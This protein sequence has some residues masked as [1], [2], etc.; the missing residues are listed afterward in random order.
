V[1]QRTNEFGVRLALGATPGVLLRLVLWQAGRVVLIGLA[2]GLAVSFAT[3][4][5]LAN[6]LFG[7]TPHDPLL[8]T[9]VSVLLLCV[10]MLATL[11]PA[12]RAARTDPMEALRYE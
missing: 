11:L 4:R 7:L 8:L 10:A 9:T 1:A 5:L 6:Q 2:A 12:R 3:N